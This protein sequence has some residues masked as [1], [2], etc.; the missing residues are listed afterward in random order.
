MIDVN[1]KDE[2]IKLEQAMKLSGAVSTG[3]EAKYAIKEGRVKVNEVIELARGK[4]LR[5][6]DTFS[7]EGNDYKIIGNKEF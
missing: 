1:I 2:F 4:K 3:S 7:F 6:N 5:N